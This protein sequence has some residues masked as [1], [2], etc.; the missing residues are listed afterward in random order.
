MAVQSAM[1]YFLL[2]QTALGGQPPGALLCVWRGWGGCSVLCGTRGCQDT[3]TA[4]TA[5]EKNSPVTDVPLHLSWVCSAELEACPF[6]FK[7]VRA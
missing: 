7:V 2:L 4:A 5:A 1:G 3:S 6:F